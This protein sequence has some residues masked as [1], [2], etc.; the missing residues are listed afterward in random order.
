MLPISDEGVNELLLSHV[1]PVLCLFS[2]A[3][4]VAINGLPEEGAG[5][6]SGRF[7]ERRNIFGPLSLRSLGEGRS[8]VLMPYCPKTRV[9][10]SIPL[11]L[12]RRTKSSGFKQQDYPTR[13]RRISQRGRNPL[14]A[15]AGRTASIL[16]SRS[17]VKIPFARIS[18]QYG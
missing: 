1:L 15:A 3:G 8:T 4:F 13:F 7:A 16:L 11:T 10:G 14:P 2:Q 17:R 6:R 5:G 12:S 18:G 9:G